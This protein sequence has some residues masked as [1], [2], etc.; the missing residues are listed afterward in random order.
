MIPKSKGGNH[1]QT[2]CADCHQAIHAHFTNTDLKLRYHTSEALLADE[3]FSKTVSFLRKQD[4]RRR[5]R[6]RVAKDR[7]R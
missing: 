1:T 2:L 3:R 4:P 5:Y 7:R 6:T